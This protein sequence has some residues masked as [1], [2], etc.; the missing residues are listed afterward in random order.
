[1]TA[2]IS[3]LHPGKKRNTPQAWGHSFT[4][5][6]K[7]VMTV[8]L[9]FPVLSLWFNVFCLILGEGAFNKLLKLHL[10]IFLHIW[11]NRTELNSWTLMHSS[12]RFGYCF[13]PW[14][15]RCRELTRPQFSWALDLPDKGVG[16][17]CR[18]YHFPASVASVWS[19]PTGSCVWTLDPQP[20]ALVLGGCRNFRRGRFSTLISWLWMQCD[21]R[22]HA[23]SR[24]WRTA[25]HPKT[26][27]K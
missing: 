12:F 27:L 20:V 16:V 17:S 5:W 18:G 23:L 25:Q 21:W 10:V 6:E 26:E 11:K 7:T 3:E 4:M 22:P 19:V 13:F 24:P 2:G 15:K 8:F 1:M 9:L 14:G